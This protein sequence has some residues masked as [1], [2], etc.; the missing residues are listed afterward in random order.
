MKKFE[1]I[2][3][4]YVIKEMRGG[5]GNYVGPCDEMYRV[6]LRS[7]AARFTKEQALKYVNENE[8]EFFIEDAT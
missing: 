8:G 2:Y 1:D 6:A 7:M 4:G 5:F 3:A